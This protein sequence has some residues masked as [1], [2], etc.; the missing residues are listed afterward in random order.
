MIGFARV[1]GNMGV[2]L[3]WIVVAA[4]FMSHESWFTSYEWVEDTF[5]AK[6]AF[7]AGVALAR[8]CGSARSVTVCRAGRVGS[9]NSPCCAWSAFPAF[10]CSELDYTMA[11]IS[12]CSWRG[13]GMVFETPPRENFSIIQLC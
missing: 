11:R 2:L 7:I 10:G 12:R 13:T 6:A 1:L 5:A 9:A 4:Y 3:F 8:I